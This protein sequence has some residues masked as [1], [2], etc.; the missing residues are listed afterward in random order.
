MFTGVSTISKEKKNI[1]LKLAVHIACH[2]SIRSIDHL[3]DLLKLHGKGSPLENLKLHRTKC[4]KLILNVLSPSILQSLV[5]DIGNSK[6]SLIVDESTDV[7]VSKYMAYCIRYFS[8]S[9]QT[10]TN[11]FL[12]LVIVER[13]TA[14]A[15]CELTMQFLKEINLNPKNIIGLGVDGASNL[16]GRNHSLYTLL[17]EISPNLQLIKCICHSL[18]T[19]SSKASDV[20]PAH[21]EFM[22]RE[23]VSWFSYSAL[24]KMEYARLY[25]TINGSCKAQK[26][27]VK[28]SATRWLAF[29]NCVSVVLDQWLELKTCFLMASNNEKCHS[30]RTLNE[31]YKDNTNLLYFTFLR[32]ILK[33]VTQMNLKFQCN[34]ADITN[35]YGELKQLMLSIAKRI[36]KPNFLRDDDC[37][38]ILSLLD[39]ERVS[40]ALKNNLALLPLD[41]IDY[42][43]KFSV[44][45]EKNIVKPKE[46]LIVKERCAKFLFT[47]CEELVQRL[48][49]NT[50]V[51]EK[52]RCFSPVVFLFAIPPKFKDLPLELLG[53]LVV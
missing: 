43:F 8:K 40:K 19:C 15:L 30:A 51:I 9:L 18:N 34:N 16:C 4:S 33:D 44:L 46:L 1:D 27:L 11:E 49:Q 21:L 28:L 5:E 23:T 7:S 20:L 10:I 26:Q 32:P 36:I 22:L 53:S 39:I 13:A 37:P 48:P 3:G 38:N 50:K 25:E 52:L 2:S 14:D 6:Y 42:G 41:S 45:A 24:R 31:M 12:G 47:L 17:R 29:Y 35:A